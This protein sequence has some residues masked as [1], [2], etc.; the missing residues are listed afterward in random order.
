M[1]RI[2]MLAVLTASP[3]VLHAATFTIESAVSRALSRNPGLLAARFTV[4][5]AEGRLIQSGR[6]TNPELES[7][8]K[9]NVRGREFS[10]GVG[11]M[12]RF[13]LTDRLRLE[14]ALSR[15][16]VAIAVAE[17]REAERQLAAEVRQAAVK[18]LGIQAVMELKATQISQ[19]DELV[20]LSAKA[21]EA[22]EGSALDAAQLELEQQQIRIGLLQSEGEKSSLVFTLK[23]LLGL[24]PAD[25]LEISGNLSA[26]DSNS[27]KAQPN[28][29][30]R[31][32]FQAS[33]ARSAAARQNITIQQKSRWEDAA[34][35][36]ST[37]IERSEDA[38]DGLGT[39]GFIGLKFSVPLPFWNKNEGNIQAALATASRAELETRAVAAGI[40]AE[41]AS[42]R[43]EMAAA[44]RIYDAAAGTLLPR[45]RELEDKFLQF[46]RKGEPGA[47]LDSL[48]RARARRHDL[49]T[50]RLNALRDWHLAKSRLRAA[51]GEHSKY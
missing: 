34:F 9:P 11:F 25:G 26:P 31:P 1:L 42:A 45:A 19:T 43:A 29:V 6:F 2:L 51:L 30:D 37:E 28:V 5:E 38:P 46:Y 7:E 22:A 12:Q 17:V 44:A 15:T 35:G 49:E 41:A 40:R 27:T 50:A 4:A 23:P 24:T 21:A 13:P 39:D 3:C 48:L 16:E 10:F 36:L 47:E 33:Q 8:L 14:K 18:L 32:D 20:N